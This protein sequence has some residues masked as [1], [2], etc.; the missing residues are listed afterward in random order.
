MKFSYI[1]HFTLRLKTV[2][3]KYFSFY[4]ILRKFKFKIINQK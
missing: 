3:K 4:I 2:L 1:Q